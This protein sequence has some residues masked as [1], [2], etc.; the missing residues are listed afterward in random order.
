MLRADKI[1]AESSPK[2]AP[3]KAGFITQIVAIRA[4]FCSDMK[5]RHAMVLEFTAWIGFVD[6][7]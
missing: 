1:G 3:W 4:A 6:F 5:R 2:H 7:A